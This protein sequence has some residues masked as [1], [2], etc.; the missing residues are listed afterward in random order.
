MDTREDRF[1]PY[2]EKL[3]KLDL[4]LVVHIG[5]ESSVNSDKSCEQIS[6]SIIP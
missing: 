5:S 6:I 1:T 3:K 4:A 2:F